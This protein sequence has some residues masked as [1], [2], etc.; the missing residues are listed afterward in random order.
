LVSQIREIGSQREIGKEAAV[1]RVLEKDEVHVLK[2]SKLGRIHS[3]AGLS[4]V[5]W[6][7]EG[8]FK[9]LRSGRW[10]FCDIENRGEI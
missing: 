8:N 5:Q 10:W 2:G 3:S 4:S 9:S 1:P 7:Q 6:L